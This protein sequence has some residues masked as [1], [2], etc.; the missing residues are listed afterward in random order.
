MSSFA[1][2][3]DLGGTNL[4]VGAFTS[5][6]ERI[7]LS[8][9]PTRVSAGPEAVVRDMCDEIRK[10]MRDCPDGSVLQGIGVGSPGP[11]ELPSGRLGA[12]PNLPGFEGFEL[13]QTLENMLQVPV[14]VE[15]DSNAAALAECYGGAGKKHEERSMCMLTL[16]TGVGAGLVL[17]GRIWHGM[18]GMAGEAGHIPVAPNGPRCSCGGRGCLELYASASG[19]YRTASELASAGDSPEILRLLKS[20]AWSILELARLADDGDA[21]AREIFGEAGRYLGAGLAGLVNVLNLPLYVIGGGVANAWHLFAP[22]M[23]EALTELSYVYRL[24]RPNLP[25]NLPNGMAAGR[26]KTRVVPAL[27]GSDAGLMGAAMLPYADQP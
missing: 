24:T 16:G 13:K 22:A 27:L 21:Q 3:V 26:G 5:K 9:I 7:G 18:N 1:I 2:G 25:K 6:F 4:R 15:H 14:Y 12:P 20:E 17:E 8:T 10:M 19:I 23:I 11:L